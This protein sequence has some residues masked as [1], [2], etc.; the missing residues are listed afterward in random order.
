MKIAY[1]RKKCLIHRNLET[2]KPIKPIFLPYNLPKNRYSAPTPLSNNP[3]PHYPPPTSPPT[4]W[5]GGVAW[6]TWN[7]WGSTPFEF[8]GR[9]S[10]GKTEKEA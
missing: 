1:F 8:I 2:E 4:P 9:G 10:E 6:V 7:T 3:T 5:Y